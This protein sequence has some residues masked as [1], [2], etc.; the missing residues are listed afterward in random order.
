MLGSPE[1]V[2][3]LAKGGLAPLASTPAVFT[4]S[5]KRDIDRFGTLVKALGIPPQ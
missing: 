4:E 5:V 1:I 3:R 2:E